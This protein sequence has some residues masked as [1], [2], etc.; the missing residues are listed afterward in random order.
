MI[1]LHYGGSDHFFE[2][3]DILYPGLHY[4]RLCNIES[5]INQ[6]LPTLKLYG[7][8]CKTITE[9][10]V[11]YGCSTWAFIEAKPEKLNCYD[12]TIEPFKPSEPFVKKIC[13]D[14]KIKYNFFIADSIQTDIEITDLLFIDTLHTYNQLIC[15]LTKHSK[16][17][18]KYIIL[19]D[20]TLFGYSDEYVYEHAS[21]I[22]KKSTIH[23]RGLMEAVNDFISSDKNWSI[24]EVFTH[25]N[26]LTI[27][28]N[29]AINE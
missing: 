19:H 9:M 26:G 6:H 16:N 24:H 23:K 17:V 18:N 15:E 29:N 11:R 12:I 14:Y 13:N 5:D 4:S 2:E 28:K 21:E 27:L 8:K 20:T 10:G 7:Q 25:N 22:V 1:K 3:K